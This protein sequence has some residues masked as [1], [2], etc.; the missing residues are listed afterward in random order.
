[1]FQRIWDRAKVRKTKSWPPGTRRLRSRL[2]KTK[3]LG[4]ASSSC[5]CLNY[6]ALDF[7][8]FNVAPCQITRA[9]SQRDV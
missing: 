9:A 1:M 7:G 5:Y 6:E 2:T 3:E 4:R 8:K